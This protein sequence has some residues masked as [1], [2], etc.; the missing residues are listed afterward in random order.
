M[1][2]LAYYAVA[3]SVLSVYG[4]SGGGDGESGGGGDVPN[5]TPAPR[6]ENFRINY[7]PFGGTQ[8]ADTLFVNVPPQDTGTN[9][10]NVAVNNDNRADVSTPQAKETEL[11]EDATPCRDLPEHLCLQEARQME[12]AL[13]ARSSGVSADDIR[14]KFEEIPVGGDFTFFVVGAG[15]VTCRKVLPES[16]TVH[17]TIF[18]EVRN[19]VPILD[20]A[21][22]QSFA[23]AW[24]TNN[25]ARTGSG[26]YDQ[27]RALFGSEWT[28]NG[29]RDGDAKVVLVY[30]SSATLGSGLFGFFR[31]SDEFTK[32]E[33]STSNEGEILYLNAD[34]SDFD[35][36]ATMAHEFQHMVRFNMKL[37]QQGSFAGE[38]E[39]DTIDEGASLHA[40]ELCG[41]SL[42]AAGGGN[43]FLFQAAQAYLQQA[44]D[45]NLFGDFNGTLKFYGGGYLLVKYFHEQ[46][47]DNNFIQF[48]TNTAIG[49]Q[50]MVNVSGVARPDLFRRFSL[51]LLASPF[52]GAVPAEGRFPV[53]GFTTQDTFDI[54][55]L[56]TVSL[57]GLVPKSVLS[58]PAGGANVEVL[59]FSPTLVRCQGGSGAE[60]I[61]Q[62]QVNGDVTLQGVLENA[63]GN[64]ALTQVET[65]DAA[66]ARTD[67][68]TAQDGDLTN[69]VT[70]SGP[71]TMKVEGGMFVLPNR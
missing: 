30:C 58:P 71:L 23:T 32:T 21:R 46:F 41:Y 52:S 64:V 50:N 14:P 47:G 48:N 15:N 54:R 19:G 9:S 13:Q 65:V 17:C 36:L 34:K 53:S 40:E 60:L 57:P 42:T 51:A 25:P 63:L 43:T 35:V 28:V 33:I 27:V 26:I 45:F 4:C 5:P 20:E 70:P 69:P 7:G 56:G 29:G 11:E 24:D 55:T 22:A 38:A 3:F 2:K 62:G 6:I 67:S 31:P 44:K 12:R 61:F 10:V 66:T 37:I 16:N 68:T 1:K 49:Y 39:N 59:P 8:V 18:A